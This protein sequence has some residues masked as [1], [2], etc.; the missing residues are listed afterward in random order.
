MMLRALALLLLSPVAFAQEIP[1]RVTNFT[2]RVVR[3]KAAGDEANEGFG[4]LVGETSTHLYVVTAAHVI[5]KGGSGA[6]RVQIA[7]EGKPRWIAAERLRQDDTFD[8]A[9]VRISKPT[10]MT[11]AKGCLHPETSY[12]NTSV[13]FIGREGTWYISTLPGKINAKRAD[14]HHRLSFD[15][16][17]VRPGNSGG[18]LLGKDG[19][20]G[21][22]LVDTGLNEGR[23]VDLR[24]IQQ[25]LADWKLPWGLSECHLFEQRVAE[26]S[27]T[28]GPC[29]G[30]SGMFGTHGDC[31]EN[32]ATHRDICTKVPADARVDRVRLYRKWAEEPGWAD[33]MEVGAGSDCDWCKFIGVMKASTVGSQ[34]TV[35]WEFLQ[36]SSHQSRSARIAIE[37]SVPSDE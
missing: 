17:G 23:A 19:L 37:Y 24:A 14:L 36:W 5:G 7:L 18:P 30:P 28:I 8:V 31:N 9:A 13:W 4:F 3:V 29:Q 25:R 11:L 21:M 16:V 20:I 12:L 1:R 22:V 2:S 33:R 27:D 15:I 6:A 10:G 32:S 35:C 34:T 26:G